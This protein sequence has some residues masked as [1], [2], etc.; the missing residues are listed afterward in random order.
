MSTIYKREGTD[1]IKVEGGN[2]ERGV[3]RTQATYFAAT[4]EE[5]WTIAP[6]TYEG[7][8]RTTVKF[9]P[10]TGGGFD[11]LATYEGMAEGEGED[12]PTYELL[13]VQEEKPI[14]NHPDFKKLAETFGWGKLSD[15]EGGGFGFP[16]TKP[17]ASGAATASSGPFAP[18]TAV[19]E[20]RSGV[21]EMF[22]VTTW[23]DVGAVWRKTWAVENSGFPD[24]LITNAGKIDTPE[25]NPP[26]P[27]GGR[28]WLLG[29][30]TARGRGSAWEITKEWQLS[31][32]GG[33]SEAI[34]GAS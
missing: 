20:D 6:A 15:E 13:L 12:K 30:V 19:G 21:S 11:V 31:G 33:F 16:K 10:H 2:D 24:A 27:P 5:K 26:E 9:S 32:R 3:A 29:G 14:Q 28:N 1:P 18:A 4:A 7:L 23:L 8:K 17:A 34:Y 25:G 22:G